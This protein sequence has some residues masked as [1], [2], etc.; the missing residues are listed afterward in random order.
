LDQA[1]KKENGSP[2]KPFSQKSSGHNPKPKKAQDRRSFPTSDNFPACA[3]PNIHGG[4]EAPRA[5]R[6][7]VLDLFASFWIKPKRRSTVA[8]EYRSVKNQPS[9]PT[10]D[11][12]P[13]C[14][15]PNIHGGAEALRVG[16]LD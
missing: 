9:P 14:V 2:T 1:K 4:A 15:G 7:D 11:N 6:L 16:Q 3:G 5:G 13:A 12:F 8:S 10:T